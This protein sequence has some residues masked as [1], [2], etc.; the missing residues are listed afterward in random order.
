MPKYGAAIDTQRIP[1]IGLR[2]QQAVAASPPSSPVEG[3]FWHDT[4]NNVIKVYLSGTW[5]TL[6][7]AGAG[8]PPSGSAGGD[9][10]GSYPS[11]TIGTGKVTSNHILDGTVA[12]GDL[13]FTPLVSGGAAGG[14]LTGTYPNP[15]IGVG[16]VTSSHILDATITDTDVAAANKDGV[17]GT[18]SLRT[19]GSGAQ[20]AAAGTHTHTG[21][22][23][24]G[25]AGGDLTGTYPN[26]D[27]APGAVDYTTI[28]G[29]LK[30]SGSAADGAE[31]LR[32]LG[33]DLHKAMP[34]DAN[35]ASISDE[36]PTTHNVQMNGM[37]LVGLA[38]GIAAQDAVTKA[39]LD[40]V[41]SGLDV[42]A[43]VRVA[44]TAPIT[45]SG[46][47]TIDGVAVI[48]GDRVLVKNN[49]T[50][51]HIYIVSS[52]A[53]VIAPEA[54]TIAEE[55]GAFTFVE[56]GTQQGTGW[57]AKTNI[58]DFDQ[59]V[60]VQFS[61][62]AAYTAGNGLTLTGNDLSVNVDNSTIEISADILR[63]KDGGITAAK[64]ATGAVDLSTTKVTG[65][66]PVAKGGT[67][68]V[69][70][71]AAQINLQGALAR[72][73]AVPALTAGVW[74]T[75]SGVDCTNGV[76]TQFMDST[77]PYEQVFLDVRQ[78]PGVTGQLQVKADVAYGANTLFY[79]AT[80]KA[81]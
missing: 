51:N 66:L 7:E 42:K 16:K 50:L 35:L 70:Y 56:R 63:N 60:W 27:I 78:N 67:G 79:Q 65:T 68:A 19:L 2:P 75:I 53:W 38:D 44:T 5:K 54:N 80:V 26:T 46:T 25:S 76:I 59:T 18:P 69:D 71:N 62:A 55:T 8:G 28:V 39:Q 61:D 23:P 15:T 57:T 52:G 10:T 48:A 43:S 77:S 1:I 72:S 14:D 33:Y 73:G 58:S 6:G 49:A 4:T 3:L 36:N 13:A 12:L 74:T 37:Q 81:F 40:A 22:T 31:A 17:V 24:G 45:L 47:Q 32:A 41:V 9:L 29:S 11:P 20:Q 34:G 21:L 64:L 30:P